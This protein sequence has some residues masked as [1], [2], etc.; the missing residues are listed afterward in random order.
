MAQYAPV[1][2]GAATGTWKGE[3][4]LLGCCND[5]GGCFKTMCLPCITFG[6]TREALHG[7][8]T[9]ESCLGPSCSFF[10]CCV[11]SGGLCTFVYSM[12]ARRDI[13]EKYNLP[14][15]PCPDCCVHFWCLPC[16]LCQ[17]RREVKARPLTEW[18]IAEVK[19]STASYEP[20][21]EM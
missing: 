11:L 9:P 16:A 21:P 14:A 12:R 3:G 15:R 13:R 19:E 20:P 1:G 17:E 10:L 6:E 8:K 4:G 18:P 2:T 7:G 5:V